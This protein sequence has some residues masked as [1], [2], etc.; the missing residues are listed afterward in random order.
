MQIP[1]AFLSRISSFKH[2]FYLRNSQINLKFSEFSVNKLLFAKFKAS[3]YFFLK[4]KLSNFPYLRNK[5]Y[6]TAIFQSNEA[7]AKPKFKI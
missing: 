4:I 7:T 2:I 5:I 1:N 6:N 3:I